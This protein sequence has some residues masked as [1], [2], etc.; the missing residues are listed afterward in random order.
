MRPSS[1]A[2]AELIRS[3]LLCNQYISPALVRSTLNGVPK[4]DH[5][6]WL[7]LLLDV[8]E[9]SNDGVDLPRG[10]VPYLP[11][12]VSA[13]LGIVDQADV[14]S[15]DVFID[16]GSG[17]G[18]ALLF[19]HLLT[20]AE[21][22]GI[23][24]QSSLMR[25]AIE[26]AERFN[27]VRTRFIQ[28]DAVDCVRTLTVGTVFFLYCPFNGKLLERFLDGLENVARTRE[29]RVCCVDMAPLE[30]PW[31]H[32]IGSSSPQFDLYRSR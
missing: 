32:N 19:V 12:P 23:E 28:A 16:V 9:V 5:D 27:L 21:C 20:G 10:C 26:R 8:Q 13:L 18:R 1:K 6:A 3:R 17:I 4:E 29:I 14:A 25:W 31:L 22:I 2:T 24:T 11:C 7:D 30:R 15:T